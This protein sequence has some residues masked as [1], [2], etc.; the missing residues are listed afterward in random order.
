VH[1]GASLGFAARLSGPY[2]PTPDAHLVTHVFGLTQEHLA[3]PLDYATYLAVHPA[4]FVARLWINSRITGHCVD[5][6]TSLTL[7]ICRAFLS[8]WFF[9]LLDDVTIQ[10]RSACP[11]S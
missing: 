3:F 7:S 10:K 6:S 2:L 1:I 9:D 11:D 4:D 5:G 8:E